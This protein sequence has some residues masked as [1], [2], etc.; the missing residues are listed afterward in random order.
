MR[1]GMPSRRSSDLDR[2]AY[3]V[4]EL[5][6]GVAARFDGAQDLFVCFRLE[7]LEREV[8]ELA[9]DLAHAQAV[10]DGSVDFNRLPRNAFAAVAIEV[11]ES[12]HV[13]HAV[14][15]LHHDDADVLD[16]GEQHLAEALRLAVLGGEEVQLT[17]LGQAVDAARDFLAELLANLFDGDAGV[18]D[19]V[20]KQ[21]GDHG[22][23][24]HPHVRQDMGDHDGM[25]HVGLAGIARLSFVALPGE[26][27]CLLEQCQ[28]VFGAVFA[29][30]CFEFAV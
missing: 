15:Q 5:L 23:R 30:L 26:A 11:P 18:L 24:V 12:P 16:H 21:P 3:L 22:D 25:H 14:G 4:Q 7:V 29:N 6:V 8:L 17:Q 9:A 27:E 20:V 13:V 28:V 19:D 1:A 2:L 10:R